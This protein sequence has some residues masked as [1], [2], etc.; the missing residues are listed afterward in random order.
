MSMNT[1]TLIKVD[2][3]KQQP[4]SK[5]D[6]GVWAQH[7]CRLVARR[8]RSRPLDKRVAASTVSV[9]TQTTATSSR[10]RL[11]VVHPAWLLSASDAQGK[12]SF[13]AAG[14]RCQCRSDRTPRRPRLERCAG[15]VALRLEVDERDAKSRLIA[16]SYSDMHASVVC[17][18]HSRQSISFTGLHIV[19][20]VD[21]YELCLAD[22][23]KSIVS[24][25][26][27]T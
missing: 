2:T 18:A 21:R 19:I 6:R 15:G 27:S 4:I 14:T 8:R 24:M 3:T 16:R 25:I 13:I 5:V 20:A 1:H 9:Q 10:V 11:D 17:Y 7:R 23:G 12:H 26:A 22:Q